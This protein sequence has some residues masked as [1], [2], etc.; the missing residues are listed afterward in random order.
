MEKTSRRIEFNL[1][2]QRPEYF[3]SRVDSF[4]LLGLL[5]LIYENVDGKSKNYV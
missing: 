4:K 1:T 3:L 5:W 2:T